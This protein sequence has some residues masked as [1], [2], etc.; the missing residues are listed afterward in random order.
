M[1]VLLY[2]AALAGALIALD[3]APVRTQEVPLL[4]LLVARLGVYLTE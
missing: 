4:D 2:R 1:P 3:L